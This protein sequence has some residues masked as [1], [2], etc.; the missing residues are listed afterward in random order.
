M[1]KKLTSLLSLLFVTVICTGCWDQRPI[2]DRMLINGLGFDI[3]QDH[4]IELNASI[5]N[6]IGKGTGAFDLENELIT[7]EADSITDAAVKVQTVL[8]GGIET[9]KTRLF[10]LGED[11]SKEKFQFIL[12][13]FN[14]TP[15]TNVNVNVVVTNK[16][17]AKDILTLENVNKPIS[18][19]INETVDRA[20][21][22]SIIP[23][24]DL[25]KVFTLITDVGID[26]VLPV[27]D[28]TKDKHVGVLGAGLFHKGSYTG[29][30][31]E[32]SDAPLMLMMMD[33][34]NTTSLLSTRIEKENSN[35]SPYNILSYEI[36]RP[37]RKL[38]VHAS[39]T[40]IDVDIP[41]KVKLRIAESTNRQH[42][43]KKEI[44]SMIEKDLNKR[45]KDVIKQTQ[46]ANSDVIGV[47]R[48][49]KEHN[50]NLWK[51]LD[52]DKKY[53][54]IQIHPKFNIYISS[55]GVLET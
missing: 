10:L 44:K 43:S 1:I 40:K 42:L 17:Q 34:F 20:K 52:W 13:Q 49:I 9:A 48:Y 14:R 39:N 29:K 4:K 41:I 23:N 35:V 51:S 16:Q 5:L 31:I 21:R 25:Q 36:R 7:T 12:D 37:S 11:F 6:I 22:L 45:A 32:K 8:P 55:T 54:T 53:P 26:L 50:P 24:M 33:Q 19:I 38:I 27:I 30:Y 2:K 15:F 18:F 3:K 28:E 47:G 46:Q